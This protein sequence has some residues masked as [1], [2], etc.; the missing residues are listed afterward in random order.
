MCAKTCKFKYCT[1]SSPRIS[2]RCITNLILHNFC[3]LY[4][5]L[6]TFVTRLIPNQLILKLHVNSIQWQSNFN[7]LRHICGVGSNY[8]LIKPLFRVENCLRTPNDQR[9]CS[10]HKIYMRELFNPRVYPTQEFHLKKV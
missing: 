2:C 5:C 3:P 6:K 8:M 4:L 10:Q 1:L 9:H 7:L